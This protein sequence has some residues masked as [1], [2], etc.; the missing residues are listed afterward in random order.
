MVLD[1]AAAAHGRGKKSL[2]NA[3]APVKARV[4]ADAD[5]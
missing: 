4:T 2:D 1:K 3:K 5:T